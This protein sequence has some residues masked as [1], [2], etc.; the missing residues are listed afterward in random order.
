[1][2]RRYGDFFEKLFRG[3]LTPQ[4]SQR[5]EYYA[6]TLLHQ[7]DAEGPEWGAHTQWVGFTDDTPRRE[8]RAARLVDANEMLDLWYGVREWGVVVESEESMF[9]WMQFGGHAV[10]L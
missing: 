4:A 5:G 7:T 2:E 6:L 1:M 3:M 10:V 9:R 8:I